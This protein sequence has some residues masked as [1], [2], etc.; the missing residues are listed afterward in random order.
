VPGPGPIPLDPATD[1][2][3]A[4]SAPTP[5]PSAARLAAACRLSPWSGAAILFRHYP[6]G[7]VAATGRGKVGIG[8]T[9]NEALADLVRVFKRAK[10]SLAESAEKPSPTRP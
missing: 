2:A 5:F 7:S 3:P 4:V 8:H 10:A 6:D 9:E 1:V